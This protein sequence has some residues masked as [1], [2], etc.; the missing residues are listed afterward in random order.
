MVWTAR[1]VG[2]STSTYDAA[3]PAETGSTEDLWN[4]VA[5]DRTI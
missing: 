5:D 2:P 3:R 4:G 1:L